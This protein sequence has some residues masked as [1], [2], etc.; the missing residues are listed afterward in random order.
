MPAYAINI[1]SS[2]PKKRRFFSIAK[3][4]YSCRYL[5]NK[6]SYSPG[7]DVTKMTIGLQALRRFRD[8]LKAQPDVWMFNRRAGVDFCAD[9]IT[10]AA[11]F[12]P[13]LAGLYACRT[14]ATQEAHSEI[15]P[16]TH[17]I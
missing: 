17:R 7:K 2:H 5:W 8:R 14:G 4:D 16:R 12:G 13:S 9:P 10:A 1:F 3:H 6:A 11:Q 15:S